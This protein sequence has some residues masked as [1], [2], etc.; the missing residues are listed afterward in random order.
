MSE[1]YRLAPGSSLLTLPLLPEE[2]MGQ[3]SEILPNDDSAS[4]DED[5]V[6]DFRAFLEKNKDALKS[7]MGAFHTDNHS[8]W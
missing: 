3:P 1:E 2:A 6:A 4:L 8:N 7:G 5:A